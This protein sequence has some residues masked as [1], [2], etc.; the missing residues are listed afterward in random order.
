MATKRVRVPK[1]TARLIFDGEYEGIEVVVRL[2]LSIDYLLRFTG[3]GNGYGPES[4]YPEATAMHLYKDFA[5]AVLVEWNLEDDQGQPIPADEAGMGMVPP[6]FASF[7]ITKWGEAAVNPPAP[8]SG[9][10]NGGSTS[11]ADTIQMGPLK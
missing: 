5:R 7:L 11:V 1:R 8:L 3:P 4:S 10:S 6:A 2:D 9:I